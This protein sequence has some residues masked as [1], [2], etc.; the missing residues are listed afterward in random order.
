GVYL[1]A[2]SMMNESP[3]FNEV[4]AALIA[5]IPFSEYIS[6]AQPDFCPPFFYMISH[7]VASATMSL[8]SLRVVSIVAGALGPV[9]LH[10]MGR[11][12]YGE[13]A[14]LLASYLLLLNPLHVFSSQEFQPSA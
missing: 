3:A 11:R 10:L 9:A 7:P 2:W 5:A 4:M 1:R 13:S 6:R 12:L 8:A 14:A